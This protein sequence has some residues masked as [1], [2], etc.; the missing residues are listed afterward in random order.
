[1]TILLEMI[2]NI[3]LFM[4]AHKLGIIYSAGL[5]FILYG[6]IFGDWDLARR[7]LQALTDDLGAVLDYAFGIK[8]EHQNRE[9][10]SSEEPP[11]SPRQ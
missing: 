11:V 10:P 3:I 5:L 9:A 1:M 8:P 2:L 7:R 6:A 4:Q